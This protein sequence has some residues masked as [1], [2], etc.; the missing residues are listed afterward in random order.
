LID[1]SV[2]FTKGCYTGQE[3]V[4]RID[5]R[6]GNAPRPIRGLRLSAP[7][8]PGAEITI[9]GKLVGHITSAHERVALAP[10]PRSVAPP[11]DVLV[12]GAPAQV[13]ELPMR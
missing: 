13:V 11:A 12:D 4:A 5:S 2:S 6:G 7:V 10:L 3:L 9:D 1:A 8:T